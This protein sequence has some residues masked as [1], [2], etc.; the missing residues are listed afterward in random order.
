M[1]ITV[2]ADFDSGALAQADICGEHIELHLAPYQFNGSAT[3]N[4]FYVELSG[5]TG[6]SHTLSFSRDDIYLHGFNNQR[7]LM[8]SEDQLTW[9]PLAPFAEDEV[10]GT[11]RLD[12]DSDRCWLALAT[13]YPFARVVSQ[14]GH[15]LS[16][17]YA[18][19]TSSGDAQGRLCM[20]KGQ[21]WL[22]ET[23]LG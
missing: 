18:R 10:S 6:T 12:V 2:R 7:T 14:M 9:R 4:W 23:G 17:P 22:T 19:P 16:S 21:A 5:L 8:L 13:P 3:G 11:Y 1:P 20:D 15:W